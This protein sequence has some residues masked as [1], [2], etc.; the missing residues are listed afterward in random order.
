MNRRRYLV[1]QLTRADALAI[2]NLRRAGFTVEVI[3]DLTPQHAAES[4]AP[5]VWLAALE[6]RRRRA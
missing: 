4:P 1:P 5:R 3:V 2:G 6:R